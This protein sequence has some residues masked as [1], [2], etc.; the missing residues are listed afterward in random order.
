MTQVFPKDR[1]AKRKMLLEGV[2]SIAETL[3]TSGPKS[4]ELGTLAPEAVKALRDAGMFRLKLAHEMGGAEADPVTECMVLENLAYHDLT[5]GWCT[6]VG[7]TGI[8]SLGTFLKPPALARGLQQR[9]D[10]DRLDLVLSRRPRGARGRR[11]P[12]QRTLAIQQRHRPCRVGGRRHDRRGQRGGKRRP[13]D[14]DVLGVSEKGCHALRQL[15][16]RRRS[17]AAPVRS[18]ARS[19]TI[20]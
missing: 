4:E 3:R 2:D 6:M 1:A 9:P 16:R 18:T 14:R 15:A 19:R 10:P 17:Q 5:S 12:R 11:L 7:A 20:I 13:A 8:A